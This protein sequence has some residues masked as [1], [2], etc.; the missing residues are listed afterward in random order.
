M[1]KTLIALTVAALATSVSAVE[2][3]NKDGVTVN[4]KGDVKAT[5][6]KQATAFEDTYNGKDKAAKKAAEESN[7]ADT[8]WTLATL[9]AKGSAK[10]GVDVKYDTDFGYVVAGFEHKLV[11]SETSK[12]FAGVGNKQFGQLTVGK[13]N[14]IADEVGSDA[15]KENIFGKVSSGYLAG[16]AEK[17]VAYRFEGVKDLVVGADYVFL[18]DT[19]G[20]NKVLTKNATKE[21]YTL[22]LGA[23]YT[24]G[25]VTLSGA[26]GFTHFN[27]VHK[28]NKEEFAHNVNAF[29]LGATYVYDIFT[30]GAKAGFKHN[31]LVGTETKDGKTEAVSSTGFYVAPAVSVKLD[32]ATVFTG[33][34]LTWSKTTFD[35]AE[36]DL[37]HTF[38]LGAE[39][40]LVKNAK[41]FA[42][43]KFGVTTDK[44]VKDDMGKVIV[45]LERT[46]FTNDFGVGMKVEW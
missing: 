3:F 41:V 17:S 26:Y 16:D 39:Y 5:V 23:K 30:L 18:N 2:V 22:D 7:K 33:Y 25:D 34:G 31:S 37:T 19:T 27:G 32:K 8:V 14:T 4:V 12:A 6:T 42:E 21:Q 13:Q 1:K 29:D 40:E 28:E 11:G 35:K 36:A 46:N 10:V 44:E 9:E 38:N 45:D 43:Y 15:L 20:D 24:Y